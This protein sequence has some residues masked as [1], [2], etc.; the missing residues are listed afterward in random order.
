[1]AKSMKQIKLKTVKEM[2]KKINSLSKEN[3]EVSQVIKGLYDTHPEMIDDG[4]GTVIT[5]EQF[6][7]PL[8]AC[9]CSVVEALDDAKMADRLDQRVIDFYEGLPEERM[10]KDEIE[11]DGQEEDGGAKN[12][13]ERA[14]AAVDKRQK[15]KHSGKKLGQRLYKKGA[16]PFD[17]ENPT[18]MIKVMRLIIDNPGIGIGELIDKSGASLVY[19]KWMRHECLTFWYCLQEKGYVKPEYAISNPYLSE[20][21]EEAEARETAEKVVEETKKKKSEATEEE[22]VEA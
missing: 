3:P 22:Q 6:K 2:V 20:N 18:K 11:L 13:L 9:L 5:R 21:K 14:K 10:T 19:A 16:T 8:I 4:K 15:K 7:E 1:M 12:R 17:S